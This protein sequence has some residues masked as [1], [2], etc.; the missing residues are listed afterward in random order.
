MFRAL[1]NPKSSKKILDG[2]KIHYNFVRPH[3]AL[4]GKTPSEMAGINL[5][6]GDNKWKGLID[7]AVKNGNHE[8]KK[9]IEKENL[10]HW[11]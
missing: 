3:M 7:K 6:L 11:F 8:P 4:N 10:N 2:Q 1:G 5:N 9:V